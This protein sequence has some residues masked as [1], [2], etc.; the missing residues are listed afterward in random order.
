MLLPLKKSMRLQEPFYISLAI[1]LPQLILKSYFAERQFC[2]LFFNWSIID[3]GLPRWLSSKEST[4]NAGHA[5]SIPGLGR[6]PGGGSGNPLQYSCLENPHEQRSL[7][8]YRPWSHRQT[9]LK[10]L[11]THHK[12][13]NIYTNSRCAFGMLWEQC[14]FLPSSRHIILNVLHVQELL[15]TIFLLYYFYLL[16][17]YY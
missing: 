4:Y 1:C 9:L 11:S 5:G 8:G 6:S 10:Q 13:A 12:T 7:V 14:G 16:F 17:S 2:F 15:C 3:L